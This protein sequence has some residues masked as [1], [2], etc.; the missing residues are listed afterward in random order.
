MFHTSFI[1]ALK[2][3]RAPDRNCG[4]TN[5]F[6]MLELENPTFFHDCASG[7]VLTSM[8]IHVGTCDQHVWPTILQSGADPY[9][10]SQMYK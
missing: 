4:K 6:Q 2:K 9:L 1:F 7:E 3:A 5:L 10:L 8:N